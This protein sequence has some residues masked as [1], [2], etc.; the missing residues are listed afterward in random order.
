M[1]HGSENA[2]LRN[3]LPPPVLG[4]NEAPLGAAEF[5][6]MD[7]EQDAGYHLGIRLIR[8]SIR[9]FKPSGLGTNRYSRLKMSQNAMA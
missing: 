3:R 2:F 1:D 7:G 4:S 9:S 6:V 5:E 8:Y